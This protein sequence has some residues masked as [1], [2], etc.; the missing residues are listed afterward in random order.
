MY[1]NY[2]YWVWYKYDKNFS[3]P[4]AAGMVGHP[5][6]HPDLGKQ[7]GVKKFTGELPPYIDVK[8]L[9]EDLYK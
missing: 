4:E 2:L 5:W 9:M 1:E 8:Q 7:K 6:M 3:L